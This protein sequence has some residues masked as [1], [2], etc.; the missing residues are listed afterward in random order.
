MK[1]YKA[2]FQIIFISAI[3]FFSSLCHAQED[4]LKEDLLREQAN[5]I[6]GDIQ[7]KEISLTAPYLY[8][9]STQQDINKLQEDF[10]TTQGLFSLTKLHAKRIIDW[11]IQK[12]DIDRETLSAKVYIEES[13]A[14]EDKGYL[15]HKIMLF[16]IDNNQW[17][18]IIE[19]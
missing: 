4:L 16:K 7:N 9:D 14:T 5:K 15:A 2:A 13:I 17:K 8:Q 10:Y 19:K 12:V 1:Y 3:F 18:L 11:K 6:M